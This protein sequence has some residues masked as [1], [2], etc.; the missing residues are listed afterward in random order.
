[1]AM[2]RRSIFH[3]MSKWLNG[4]GTIQN[5]RTDMEDDGGLLVLFSFF[6]PHLLW[7]FFII[8]FFPAHLP[9]STSKQTNTKNNSTKQK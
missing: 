5:T 6:S 7:R 9:H 4:Y 2:R 3:S 8:F 1:M